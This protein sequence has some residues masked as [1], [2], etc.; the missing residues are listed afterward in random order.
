MEIGLRGSGAKRQ[1]FIV[2]MVAIRCPSPFLGNLYGVYFLVHIS[3][4]FQFLFLFFDSLEL[5]I[6]ECFGFLKS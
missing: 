1:L 5:F 4:Q 2:S 3:F 6:F